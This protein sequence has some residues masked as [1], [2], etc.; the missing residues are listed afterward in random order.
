MLVAC[1]QEGSQMWVPRAL[2]ADG[3]RPILRPINNQYFSY[4]AVTWAPE[5][6]TEAG[7]HCSDHLR[8]QGAPSGD[9]TALAGGA[10]QDSP[11]FWTEVG[12][13][14]LGPHGW[15]WMASCLVGDRP[16]SVYY[17]HQ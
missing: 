6:S 5:W 12:Y 13:G 3:M 16:L 1:F 4:L 17:S 8:P 14:W 7:R 2:A 11:Q 9:P 10:Y 15:P